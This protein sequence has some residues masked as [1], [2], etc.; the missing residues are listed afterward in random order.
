MHFPFSKIIWTSD[1]KQIRGACENCINAVNFLSS[2]FRQYIGKY[3]SK[4][5]KN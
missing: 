4:G 2:D 1:C 5:Q 3:E